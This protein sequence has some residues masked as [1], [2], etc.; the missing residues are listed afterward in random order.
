VQ[1][2]PGFPGPF[3]TLTFRAGGWAVAAGVASEAEQYAKLRL[4][5]DVARPAWGD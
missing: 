4:V 2:G 1:K 5:A 3:C